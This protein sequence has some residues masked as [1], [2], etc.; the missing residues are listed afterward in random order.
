V[1]DA[2]AGRV[3]WG[4][5]DGD[6]ISYA[7]LDG[8]GGGDLNVTGVT[9]AE[10]FGL[11]IDPVGNRIYWSNEGVGSIAYASL[12]T[13]QGGD[14]D[15][16]GAGELSDPA[17]PVI[18]TTPDSAVAPSAGGGPA[19]GSTLSCTPGTWTG[20]V[21]ESAFY[22]A[23]QSTSLQW[24]DNGQPIAGAGA[25]TYTAPSVGSYSCQSSAAN[26]AGSSSQVS[27]PIG[28]FSV[29]KAKPNRKKG[30]ALLPVTIPGPGTVVL[31]GKRLVG[32]RRGTAAGSTRTI[33]LLVKA[34]GKA[35]K[36]LLKKGHLKVKLAIAFTPSTGTSGSQ[37]ATVALRKSKPKT[38][39]ES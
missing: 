9:P 11:A 10:P 6:T 32:Q 22:R 20:D 21:L 5:Y 35:R 34:K 1:I 16:T 27:A 13:G 29:G 28:I 14:L 25:S 24:L 31:S 2:A 8:S 19:V 15:T 18:L 33:K 7:N 12:S 38:R 36:A 26:H 23:P 17:Y 30:T 39:H 3:Y 4:S 37:N